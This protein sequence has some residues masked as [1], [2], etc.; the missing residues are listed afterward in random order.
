MDVTVGVS[1]S[2]TLDRKISRKLEPL[3]SSPLQGFKHLRGKEEGIRTYTF[4]SPL[5]PF[6]TDV[7]EII[8]E[9]IPYSDFLMFENLNIRPTN[10]NKVQNVLEK[11]LL[12]SH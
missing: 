4:L 5:I 7:A 3:A 2:T 6:I 1:I 8:K 11:Y 10:L 9:T 12:T